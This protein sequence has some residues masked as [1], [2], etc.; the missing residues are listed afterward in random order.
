MSVYQLRDGGFARPLTA[1]EAELVAVEL[2]REAAERAHELFVAR[3]V[4]I[5]TT[6]EAAQGDFGSDMWRVPANLFRRALASAAAP[7]PPATVLDTGTEREHQQR[8]IAR[9]L[10]RLRD[11]RPNLD[12]QGLTECDCAEIARDVLDLLAVPF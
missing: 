12:T 7:R 1:A 5:E 11:T 2:P 6:E 8:E 9:L 3:A 10:Y 4:T